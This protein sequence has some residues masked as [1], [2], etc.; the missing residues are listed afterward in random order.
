M[1]ERTYTDDANATAEAAAG[2]AS[3]IGR[4]VSVALPARERSI[5]AALCT[6][7]GEVAAMADR[8]VDPDVSPV[9]VTEPLIEAVVSLEGYLRIRRQLVHGDSSAGMGCPRDDDARRNPGSGRRIGDRDGD[10]ERERDAAVL[11][12]DYLHAAAYAAAGETPVPAGRGLELYRVL[13]SGSTAL[14]HEFLERSLGTSDLDGGDA[15][16]LPPATVAGVA[17]DLGATALGA[18]EEIRAALETY[19]RSLAAAVVARSGETTDTDA[20]DEVGASARPIGVDLR[21]TVVRVLSATDGIRLPAEQ[22]T[23]TVVPG[24]EPANSD[25]ECHLERAREAVAALERAVDPEVTAASTASASA[26]ASASEAR[27]D[28][29]IRGDLESPLVRLE[30]ATRVPFGTG[31][32]NP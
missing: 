32:G 2:L 7:A 15:E 13:A 23:S 3:P 9:Q 29:R 24:A 8:G 17:A 26:S 1:S 16:S 31:N 12:S 4:L 22:S 18:T 25:G 30:R 6:V 20:S 11:A 28:P 5:P 21:R 19:S 14:S 27:D 10:R